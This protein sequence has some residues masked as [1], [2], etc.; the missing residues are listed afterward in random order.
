MDATTRLNINTKIQLA[1]GWKREPLADNDP[2]KGCGCC[3]GGWCW[4]SPKGTRYEGNDLMVRDWLASVETAAQVLPALIAVLSDSANASP[5][6]TGG[7][8]T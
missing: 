5:D 1:L 4:V 2:H 7:S 6:R 3:P 8:A